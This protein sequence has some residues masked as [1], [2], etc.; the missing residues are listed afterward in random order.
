MNTITFVN[1]VINWLLAD[2]S[3]IVV[4]ASVLAAMTP[5]P[6]PNTPYGKL[7]RLLDLFALNFMHAKSTGVALPEVAQQVAAIL[8]QQ[9]PAAVTVKEPS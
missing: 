8:E 5:T 1:T 7:Y 3:H 2:P 6:A 9:K 4:A